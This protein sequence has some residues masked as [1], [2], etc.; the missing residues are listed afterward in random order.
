MKAVTCLFAV[1]LIVFLIAGCGGGSGTG[2]DGSESVSTEAVS[3][4][5]TTPK[6][7]EDRE[8]WVAMDG[9]DGAETIGLVMAEHRG[10]FE[11]AD[12]F[13]TALSPVSP[14]LS[15]LD[16]I[17]RTDD[18]AVAHGPQVVIAKA[19]GAPIVIVGSMVP[20]P[21]AALIWTKESGIGGIADLRGQTI[22]I[23][24][25]AFQRDFLE[26]VLRKGGLTLDDVKVKNVGNDLVPELVKEKVDAIFG[27]S[28][29]LEG[30]DLESQGFEPVVTPVR[31]VGIPDYEELV[32]VA[33]DDRMA[34]DPEPVLDVVSAIA[35]GAV[36]AAAEPRRAARELDEDGESNPVLSPRTFRVATKRSVPLLSDDGEVDAQRTEALID[37]MYEEKMIE[38]KPSLDELLYTP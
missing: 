27:G 3:A 6:A 38:T 25:L 19:K 20:H 36:K 12:L 35:S 24:G 4:A 29:N 33:R 11:K 1:G 22:A 28:A 7:P 16:V 18:V 17:N 31:G 23:P 15:I 2:A 10:D 30:V 13:L 9:W 34:A 8:I 32:L 37:W 21:T 5:E 14:N 26:V